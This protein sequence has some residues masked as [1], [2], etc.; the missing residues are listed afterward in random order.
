MTGEG[1]YRV[2]LPPVDHKPPLVPRGRV[3][4]HIVRMSV[5]ISTGHAA[6]HARVIGT[7]F[8]PATMEEAFGRYCT[9]RNPAERLPWLSDLLKKISE[10]VATQREVGSNGNVARSQRQ[11]LCYWHLTNWLRRHRLAAATYAGATTA[12]ALTI[13]EVGFNA[14]HS[15]T[16]FLSALNDT[17]ARYYGFELAEDHF[18]SKAIPL[19]NNSLF[20]GQLRLTLGDSNLSVP[21][22]FKA[23]SEVQCDVVSLDGNHAI[24]YIKAD[25]RNL[26][27]RLAPGGLVLLDD[28]PFWSRMFDKNGK[29]YEPELHAV[30]C[31]SLPGRADDDESAQYYLTELKAGKR[32]ATLDHQTRRWGFSMVATDG[33]CVARRTTDEDKRHSWT[34]SKS[35]RRKRSHGNGGKS[36]EAVLPGDVH[37]NVW[38]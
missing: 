28:V 7:W 22:F 13:C 4:I 33:F 8:E 26:K 24:K 35:N 32:N 9:M 25:W 18:L 34:I 31:I 11:T 21:A 20:P 2:V 36:D 6:P 3:A 37:L 12:T 29:I 14:G 16:V 38:A 19:L 17:R 5:G 1:S 23:H 30:G 27:D 15:A 10:K